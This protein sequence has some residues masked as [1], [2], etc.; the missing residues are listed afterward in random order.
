MTRMYADGGLE[1]AEMFRRVKETGVTTSL[2]MVMPDP[3]GPSGQANWPLIL[4][5][6]LPYVDLFVPS[7][8]ELLFMLR[9]ARFDVATS[10]VGAADLLEALAVEEI[11]SLGDEALSM[12]AK[13]VVLKLGTR[14]IYLRTGDQLADLGR[15][16]PSVLAAWT[17][18]QLWVPCYRPEQIISTVG[19]GDA[20]IAGFLAAFLKDSGPVLSLSVAVAT[21]ASCVEEPGALGGVRTW[22]ETRD[23]MEAGWPRLPLDLAPR[24]WRWDSAGGVWCGPDDQG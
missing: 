1:L 7:V 23:R 21:G 9:R 2:D 17:G 24:D 13:I 6:V 19:T 20:A 16:T 8:E 12:G 3:G 11:T 5:R 14:G 15:G 22:D 18:R 10:Q 4:S